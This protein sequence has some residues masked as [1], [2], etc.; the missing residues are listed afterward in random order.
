MQKNACSSEVI[1]RKKP[2]VFAVSKDYE[3][4]AHLDE[5]VQRQPFR[6]HDSSDHSSKGCEKEDFFASFSDCAP[7]ENSKS[8][9][10]ELRDTT[11]KSPEIQ[12]DQPLWND[13]SS[14]SP[15]NSFAHDGFLSDIFD[16]TDELQNL[17]FDQIGGASK[18]KRKQRPPFLW[19]RGKKKIGRSN[20]SR[21]C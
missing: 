11:F 15:R 12:I 3:D 21:F 2:D 13:S 19:T 7:Q 8:F 4:F 10:E 18:G 1:T 9:L 20:V 16:D 17:N 6:I 14:T 5:H